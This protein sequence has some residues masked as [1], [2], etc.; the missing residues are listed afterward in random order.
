MHEMYEAGAT[1]REVGAAHGLSGERVRQLF[2]AYGFPTRSRAEV[3][4]LQAVE[5]AEIESEQQSSRR[6]RGQRPP[7]AR[8]KYSD[9]ELI[10]CLQ[11]ASRAVGGVLST[12]AY[13]RLAKT[14]RFPDGRPWPTHQTHFHRFGS[15]RKAL[16]AAG[17]RANPSSPIA[18]QRLFEVG[19]C[20]D[21]IRHAHRELGQ[22]PSV[23]EYDGVASDS[24][25]A[26]P[27]SAT[28]R[29]LC[30]SWVEALRMAGVNPDESPS[31]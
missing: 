31:R 17:L 22:V 23:N 12:S 19:H 9:D 18:G 13:T 10:E 16:Q 11:E 21:A 27:S 30:G 28:I 26:L 2:A 14:Q 25:G 3:R 1:L 7:W 29:N 24:N 20:I 15:W 4:E 8:K 5:I 6:G